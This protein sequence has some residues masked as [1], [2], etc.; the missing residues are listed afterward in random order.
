MSIVKNDT[1]EGELILRENPEDLCWTTPLGFL[2]MIANLVTVRFPVNPGNKFIVSGRDTPGTDD[3]DKMW[4]R[5]DSNRN[6][7]GWFKF[8]K[9]KWR[10]VYGYNGDEA[11]WIIG[12]S[13]NIREG[14]QLLDA[15]VPG[16]S[17]NI[18]NKLLSQ[19][20]ET[21]PGSGVYSYFA[22]RYIGY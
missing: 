3:I 2:K 10:R 21:S 20:V 12:N 13:G 22:V 17:G 11:I 1:L 16:L 18:L 19:Y 15:S 6:F 5:E 14:F 8:I 4:A 9:G 7:L